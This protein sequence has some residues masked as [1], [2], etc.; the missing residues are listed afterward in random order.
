[1]SSGVAVIEHID[2]T[3]MFTHGTM[4]Y[5]AAKTMTQKIVAQRSA[6]CEQRFSFPISYVR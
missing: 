3:A 1:V 2:L 6:Q 4:S 5:V